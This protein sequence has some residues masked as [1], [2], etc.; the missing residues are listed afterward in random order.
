MVSVARHPSVALHHESPRVA[1]SHH[2]VEPHVEGCGGHEARHAGHAVWLEGQHLLQDRGGQGLGPLPLVLLAG[3][4]PLLQGQQ[5][6]HTDQ[7]ERV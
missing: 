6:A 1:V 5:Q 4:A 3:V 7:C 2:R